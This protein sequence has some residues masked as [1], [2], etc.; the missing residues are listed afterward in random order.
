MTG[1]AQAFRR[2]LCHAD[3]AVD[4]IGAFDTVKSL[5]VRLPFL[6][7]LADTK[8]GFHNHA[9]SAC[10]KAGFHALALEETRQVYAPVMW[11]SDPT[12]QG[13]LEQVWFPGT[14]GDV[15][16]Q[17][18]GFEAARP[19]AN[20]PLVWIL[21]QAE[22]RGLP[23]PEAW[24]LRFPMN[25]EAPSVGQWRGFSKMFLLRRP[26]LVGADPSERLH[27]SAVARGTYP[28]SGQLA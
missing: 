19:L 3:V 16:G 11:D 26:R 24:R 10:V 9:L 15:G 7:R 2:A 25:L 5:G 13:R 22:R 18:G 20:I 14:H 8:H 17:L 28:H 4:M 27:D 21:G 1:G 12:W 23:L 6:W